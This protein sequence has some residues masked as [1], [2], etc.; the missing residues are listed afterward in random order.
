VLLTSNR[1]AMFELAFEF[2][3]YSFTDVVGGFDQ[4]VELY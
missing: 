4:A 1:C 3:L 2:D